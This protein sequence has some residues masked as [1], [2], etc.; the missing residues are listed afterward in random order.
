LRK[1]GIELRNGW[2]RIEEWVEYNLGMGGIELR[3]GWNGS[4]GWNEAGNGWNG[5][6]EWG[7][8]EGYCVIICG[9]G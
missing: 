8:E 4:E 2:N 9:R 5:S 3:N 7:K 1:G 6:E